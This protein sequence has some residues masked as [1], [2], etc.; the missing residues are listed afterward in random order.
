[1]RSELRAPSKSNLRLYLAGGVV[2]AL[3]LVGGGVGMRLFETHAAKAWSQARAIEAVRVISPKA[4]GADD[5]LNLPGQLQ[6]YNSAPIYPRVSGYVRSWLVDIGA[7]VKA[8]Q[9]LALID[10]P[11]LDQEIAKARADVASATANQNLS[12]LTANRWTDLVASDAVSRQEADEKSGDLEARIAASKAASANLQRLL[13]LKAF[14]RITAPFDGVVTAR[15]IDIG[16]LVNAGSGGQA[17][18]LFT[19]SNV[20]K[21]RIYVQAPQAVSAGVKPGLSAS[22]TLPEYP[23]RTYPARFVTASGAIGQESG[24][25]LVE[26]EADNADGLLK[27]GAYAEVKLKL[28]ALTG[29]LRLPASTL[30]FRSGGA[31]IAVVDAQSHVVLHDVR[32]GRDLGSVIELASGLGPQDRVIDNPPD[33]LAAGDLVRVV[34][35]GGG[36]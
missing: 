17:Q 34:Q 15:T 22:L 24:A 33:S 26:L 5:G 13:A 31:Q 36:A 10:T 18:A 32:I 19:I 3:V 9:A 16:D 28:P 14:A 6:A 12:R 2:A 35:Q 20:S 27:P 4:S 30:I 11:E 21:I 23:G 29:G 8:G 7:K 1:M 25:L